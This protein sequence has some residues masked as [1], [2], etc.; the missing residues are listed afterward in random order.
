MN[1]RYVWVPWCQADTRNKRTAVLGNVCQLETCHKQ[2]AESGDKVSAGYTSYISSRFC[3]PGVSLV[4]VINK[5]GIWLPGC[6]FY[7]RHK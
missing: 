7:K 4:H 3:Y 6:H 1:Q 5:Q 2:R